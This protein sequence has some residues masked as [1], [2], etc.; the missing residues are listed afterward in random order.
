MVQQFNR[1]AMDS[2]L[3]GPTGVQC[4]YQFDSSNFTI[5]AANR[6]RSNHSQCP[7][8][9]GK[10]FNFTR[11]TS[12]NNYSLNNINESDAKGHDGYCKKIYHVMR[13]FLLELNYTTH[14]C[15]NEGEVKDATESPSHASP[16]SDGTGVWVCLCV[17]VSVCGCGCVCVWVCLCVGVGVSV[18]GCVCVWVCLCVGVSV[19]GCVCVWVWVCLCVGVSVCGCVCVWVCLCVGVSVCGCVCV[20]VCLCV[21]VSVC[22]CVCVWACLCVGVCLCGCVCVS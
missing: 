20:W 1:I 5:G 16:L 19:C 10:S 4:L 22:G 17:G 21:G 11:V 18:C 15:L 2:G 13:A 14:S 6:S 9:A 3:V 8:T 7:V 12:I